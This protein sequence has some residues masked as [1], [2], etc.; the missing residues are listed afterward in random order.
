MVLDIFVFIFVPIYTNLSGRIGSPGKCKN[1]SAMY[2]P[3]FQLPTDRGIDG[4]ALFFLADRH[5][6][7]EKF[8]LPPGLFHHILQYKF[9][10]RTPA[11]IAMADEKNFVHNDSSLSLGIL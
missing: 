9:R 3:L 6:I 10:H 5:G 2:A 7:D 4:I 8:F 1:S 11:N